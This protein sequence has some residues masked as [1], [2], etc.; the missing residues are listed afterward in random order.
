MKTTRKLIASVVMTMVMLVTM[1]VP[2][3]AATTYTPVAGGKVTFTKYLVLDKDASVP[4]DTFTYTING[5]TAVEGSASTFAVYAGNDAN[6]TTGAATVGSATFTSESATTAGAANDDITN[7]ADKK[8]AQ[9]TVVI[10]FSGVTFKEP[11]VYRYVLTENVLPTT[12]S[13]NAGI[14]YDTANS[15]SRIRTIDVYVEDHNGTLVVGNNGENANDTANGNL[16]NDATTPAT[17]G[18][19]MYVGSVSTAPANDG[20]NI[21]TKSDSFIN[22]YTTYDLT[23]SKTVTGNQG[24]RDKYFEFTVE[25]SGAN[26]ETTYAVDITNADA[27]TGTNGASTTAHSN[28]TSITTNASGSA[29]QKF[30]LQHD[31]SIVIK[32]LAENTAYTIT[33]TDESTDG[34]TTT[35]AVTGD[36]TGV[37]NSDN[38]VSDTGI[39][40]D[41]T[42]AFT[43]DKD[44]IIPTGIITKV[45]PAVAG[46]V[47]L[48]AILIVLFVKSKKDEDDEEEEA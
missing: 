46:F 42:V 35:A 21:T 19:V 16:L 26:G 13:T 34:Y 15:N 25:I 18:Y 31:Q 43:N 32:G 22:E 2:S 39:N 37:S 40:A 30:Y 1:I 8:Y 27:T 9:A 11:G 45:G 47:V 10:D 5:G 3:M 23:L 4:N 24:S 48:S 14:T 12:G 38:E 29:T 17:A 20:S 7:S 33:E 6:R 44:G 36:T 41:T 28:P